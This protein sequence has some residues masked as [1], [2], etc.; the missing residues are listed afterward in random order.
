[1]T[2]SPR[3]LTW[4]APLKISRPGMWFV[5]I[6]FYLWPTGGHW[7]V[8]HSFPFYIG[9]LS[10]TLPLNLL[11][12]GIN[13]MVDFDVDQ[14]HARKGSYVFGA[15]A[16]RSEL[17]QLPLLMAVTNLCPI[18]V[19]AVVATERVNSALWVLCFLLCNIV[20]NIPPLS[21]ARK[22][23]W[24]LP[25]VLLG[26]SCITMFSCEINNIPIP[27]VGGWLFHWLAMT[28]GQLHG[29]M[30]DIDDDAKCGKN[31]TVVKLGRLKAQWLMWTLTACAAL[32]TYV[33]LGSVV[34]TTYYLIDLALSVYS[35]TRG[36]GSLEKHTTTI[37]KVQSI[38]G[39]LY[40]F[41]AWSSQVFA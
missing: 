7:S 23:P 15:R 4:K 37:F 38:L 26:V 33:L 29:E 25:C 3:V 13:D 39:V 28:R 32:V 2:V 24:E 41:Y 40:L 22:G 9:L 21:L 20:Y 19:L 11:M 10:S 35:H 5:L 36:A 27:S 31:T 30:V 16:S 6:W 34:L 18:V 8:F 1:M 17:A 12:F 14:L